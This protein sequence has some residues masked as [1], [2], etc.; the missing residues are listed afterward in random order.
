M[1]LAGPF[2]YQLHFKLCILDIFLTVFQ[3]YVK[4]M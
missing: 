1:W 3:M 2:Y 4:Q